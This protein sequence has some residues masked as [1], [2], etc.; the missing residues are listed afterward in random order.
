MQ[1]IFVP[2]YK[3]V[4][5]AAHLAAAKLSKRQRDI[6][7][8][9]IGVLFGDLQG[10]PANRGACLE[11]IAVIVERYAPMTPSCLNL[12]T[13]PVVHICSRFMNY[14]AFTG[15]DEGKH[16]YE[17]TIASLLHFAIEKLNGKGAIFRQSAGPEACEPVLT[18]SRL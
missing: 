15:E 9:W 18:P 11:G 12:P 1:T 8:D 13:H 2:K 17:Q 6:L 3:E 10:T 4:E 14:F 5:L 7:F 16:R